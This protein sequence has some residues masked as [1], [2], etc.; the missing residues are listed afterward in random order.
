MTDVADDDVQ[1][2][3]VCINETIWWRDR[4]GWQVPDWM[5]QL[6]MKLDLTSGV[7][8][9]GKRGVGGTNTAEPHS[10]SEAVLLLGSRQAAERLGMKPRTFRNHA[11]NIDH[12]KVGGKMVFRLA[13]VTRYAEERRGNS[14][15]PV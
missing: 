6:G 14:T 1:R 13:D 15:R 3:L 2:A 10:D 5:R 8:L 7:S 9:W 12:E 11:K 4:N